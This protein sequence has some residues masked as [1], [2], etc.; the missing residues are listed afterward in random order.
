MTARLFARDGVD[1]TTMAAIATEAEVSPPTVF[2]YFG[3][4][5]NILSALIFEGTERERSKHLSM[6]RKTNC[7]FA[8][9]LGTLMVEC[10]ENT[11]GIAGKRV[12]WYAEA[13][14]IRHPNTE[15]E[16]QFSHS[17][18]ELRNLFAAFLNDYDVVMRNREPMDARFLANMFFDRWTA[19][20]FSYIKAEDMT[21]ESHAEDLRND[22]CQLVSLLFDDDFASDS[23]LR[24]ASGTNGANDA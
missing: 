9:V 10:T 6:A 4:K 17:D 8:D 13:A 16:K 11:M 22:A 20:Y 19:R 23:P 18:R 24:P 12:W 21:L 3:S 2:N 7:S 1:A 5:E 15:F 14:N